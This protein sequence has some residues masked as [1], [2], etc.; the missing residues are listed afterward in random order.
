MRLPRSFALLGLLLLSAL[1]PAAASAAETRNL[2]N[3]DGAFP[4]NELGGPSTAFPSTVEVAGA[5]GT[6]IEVTLTTFGLSANQDL[7]MALVGPNGA[8]VMLL[9]DACSSA[10]VVSSVLTFTDAAPIFVPQ[11]SCASLSRGKVKPTNY[12]PES[13]NFATVGGPPGPYT[14]SL[15]VF[16]GISPE[17]TWRLFMM[18]DTPLERVGF[19]MDAFSLNLEIEPPSPAAPEVRTVTVPG[20]TVT[21]PG[22]TVTVPTASQSKKTGKRAAA[23]AK[24]AKK[25]SKEAGRHQGKGPLD[26]EHAAELPP[27]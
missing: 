12:E 8:Q 1:A 2:T 3:I 15:S 22:P 7:D 5:P 21:V 6:I 4:V 16:D 10:T 18:D 24:C 17:G 14:N 9:S 25:K 13:D 26:D 11:L 19:G 27:V 23:L 20:P